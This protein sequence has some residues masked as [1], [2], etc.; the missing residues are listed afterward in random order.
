MSRTVPPDAW[1]PL[2]HG[3]VEHDEDCPLAALPVRA[4]ASLPSREVTAAQRTGRWQP[5][6]PTEGRPRADDG[7]ST[8]RP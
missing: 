3:V 5:T 1:C 6:E 7:S 4:A 8:R 2:C